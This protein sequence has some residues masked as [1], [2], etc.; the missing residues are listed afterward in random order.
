MRCSNYFTINHSRM[1]PVLGTDPGTGWQVF[2]VLTNA[3]FVV[4]HAE[5]VL[6][7]LAHAIITSGHQLCHRREDG[8]PVVAPPHL[9]VGVPSFCPMSGGALPALPSAMQQRELGACCSG[10]RG[11]GGGAGPQL[12]LQT[13]YQGHK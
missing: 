1:L 7:D 2:P 8:L 5:R 6:L 10:G 9:A 13:L 4:R 3:F 11:G 12:V